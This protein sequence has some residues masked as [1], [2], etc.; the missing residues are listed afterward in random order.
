MNFDEEVIYIKIIIGL[1]LVLTA[2]LFVSPSSVSANNPKDVNYSKQM[3]K[4]NK[5][6]KMTQK[7]DLA[8]AYKPVS[9]Y[10]TNEVQARVNNNTNVSQKRLV[11]VE[12]FN[13]SSNIKT[14]LGCLWVDLAPMNS[15]GMWAMDFNTPTNNLKPGNYRIVYTYQDE[16]GMWHHIK[17][18]NHQVWDGSYQAR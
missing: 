10:E 2:V 13:S 7:N 17:S 15:G 3:Y 9:K 5:V 4:Q 1:F 8:H 11:C 16:G 14:H 6:P 18:I 12:A